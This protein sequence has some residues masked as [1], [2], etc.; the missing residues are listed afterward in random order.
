MKL[1]L[2]NH[3]R[4]QEEEHDIDAEK[5]A[6]VYLGGVQEEAVADQDKGAGEK[7]AETPGAGSMVEPGLKTGVAL[8]FEIGSKGEHG[9]GARRGGDKLTEQIQRQPQIKIALRRFGGSGGKAM[10]RIVAG[11]LSSLASLL[12]H[13]WFDMLSLA[14]SA[15]TGILSF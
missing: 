6:E 12:T 2:G 4:D 7:P 8:D 11:P 10:L 14:A 9:E 1:E 5:L 15:A 13:G 3:L